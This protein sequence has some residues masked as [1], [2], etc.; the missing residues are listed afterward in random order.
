V[1]FSIDPKLRLRSNRLAAI[2]ILTW[3]KAITELLIP[4]ALGIGAIGFA[5]AKLY[6]YW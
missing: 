2:K 1:E 6:A 4:I 5:L 3:S